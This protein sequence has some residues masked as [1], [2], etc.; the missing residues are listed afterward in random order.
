MKKIISI[1]IVVLFVSCSGGSTSENQFEPKVTSYNFEERLPENMQTD[2]AIVYSQVMSMQAQMNAV[3][4]FMTNSEWM[5]NSSGYQS[6]TTDDWSYEDYNIEYSYD[7][8]GNQYQFLYT[9]TYQGEVYYTIEG[10]QMSDGSAGYWASSIDF[11]ALGQGMENM[12]DYTTELSWT[13]DTDGLNMEMSF[14]FGDTM[15]VFYEMNINNDGSGYFAYTLNND[16][17]YSAL[18]N[19][20]GTGKWTNHTTSPPSITYW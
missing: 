4:V 8:V 9:V 19:A 20:N 12:P 13:S 18:W 5:N 11:E 6:R 14:D 16:L 10:W 15:Q 2:A 3:G 7:L 17:T 1:I